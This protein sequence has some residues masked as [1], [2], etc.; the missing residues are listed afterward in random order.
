MGIAYNYKV[1]STRS[2][3]AALTTDRT[4]Y[5]ESTDENVGIASIDVYYLTLGSLFEIERFKVTLGLNAGYGSDRVDQYF[6]LLNVIL[7]E[8][9]RETP[10]IYAKYFRLKL[11]FGIAFN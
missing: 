7:P 5:R 2:Y 6:N 1:D 4:Y 9:G 11:V 8:V 3:Y 10:T